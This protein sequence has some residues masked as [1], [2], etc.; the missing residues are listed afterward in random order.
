MEAELENSDLGD[1]L[2]LIDG[3][4]DESLN[5][6]QEEINFFLEE[7]D[8]EEKSKNKKDESNPFLALFGY[9]EKTETKKEEKKKEK[10]NEKKKE[11][12]KPVKPDDWIEKNYIRKM[13]K[14]KAEDMT[15]KIF[16]IYKKAHGMVS[17]T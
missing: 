5:S 7:K 8:E 14:E 6:L 9:Y 17:Y 10:P 13:A 4:T 12:D 16:D 3:A 11:D 15:F 1:A 2:K